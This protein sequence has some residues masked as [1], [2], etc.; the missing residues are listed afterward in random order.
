MKLNEIKIS[1]NKV[2]F[3]IRYLRNLNV[4]IAF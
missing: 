1:V 4:H 3:L 2:I